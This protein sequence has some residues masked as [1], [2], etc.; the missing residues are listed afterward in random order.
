MAAIFLQSLNPSLPVRLQNSD[1]TNYVTLITAG[2]NGTKVVAIGITSNDTANKNIILA[3][4]SGGVDYPLGMVQVL[5]NA[6]NT[7]AIQS[8]NLLEMPNITAAFIQDNDGSRVLWLP[9]NTVL[10]VKA[11]TAVTSTKFI[12]FNPTAFNL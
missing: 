3:I 5:A 1:S 8:Q 11:E 6:G 9:P 4:T 7:N 12:N 10:K 2:A